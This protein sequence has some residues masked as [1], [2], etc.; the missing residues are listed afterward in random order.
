MRWLKALVRNYAACEIIQ[1]SVKDDYDYSKTTVEN[2]SA[3]PGIYTG[4]F[5][6][7]RAS[8]DYSWHSNYSPERQL[9]QDMAVKSCIGKTDP[10][11]RPW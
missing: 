2:Y 10:Q 9:W 11:A 5:S 1:Y 7:I 4:E 8:R 6:D 3:E